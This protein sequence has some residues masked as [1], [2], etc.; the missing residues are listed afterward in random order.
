MATFKIRP[1]GEQ[2]NTPAT[3]FKT[4]NIEGDAEFEAGA[5]VVLAGAG[6]EEAGANPTNIFGVATAASDSYEWQRDTQGFTTPAVPIALAN[7][8]FRG[9]LLGTFSVEDD[10]GAEYGITKDT[11]S[12]HWVVDK[13]KT[14]ANARVHVLSYDR[15]ATPETGGV[16]EVADGDENVPVHFMFIPEFRQVN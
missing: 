8:E 7:E 3:R 12:G 16:Q 11:D 15:V 10:I 6:V 13:T 1:F 9:T 5:V 4:P 2:H 14:G